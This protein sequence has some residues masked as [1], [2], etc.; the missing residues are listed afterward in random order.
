[1]ICPCKGC[2]KAGCGIYHDECEP[3]LEWQRY[4]RKQNDKRNAE[5]CD[6]SRDHEMKY[7]RNLKQGRSKRK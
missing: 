1:M 2:E 4:R 3:Y 5:R 6:M 7:R